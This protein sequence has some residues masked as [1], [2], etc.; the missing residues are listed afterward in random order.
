MYD[1]AEFRH[2]RYLLTI[3]ERRGF[4]AAA[5]ELHTSQPNLSV[6]AKQFQEL[7]SVRLFRKTKSG[8]IRITQTGV[9]FLVL[10]KELLDTRDQIIDAL[11]AIERGNVRSLVFG[12]ASLADPDLFREM[13]ARHKAIVPGCSIRAAYGDSATLIREVVNRAL[14]AAIITGRVADPELNVELVR[15][16]PVVVCLRHDDPRLL[17]A[18]L[19]PVDL[20]GTPAIFYDPE[21]HPEVH[22][23]LLGFLASVGVRVDQYSRASHPS[24]V[25]SLVNDGHG[26]ALIRKGTPLHPDVVAR[27]VAG[28]DWAID[29]QVVYRKSEYPKTLPILIRQLRKQHGKSFVPA[30]E[31]PEPVPVQ[32]GS[33]QPPQAVRHRP[34]Q[35]SL[36]EEV[37]FEQRDRA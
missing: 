4:R 3:L 1:W 27:H 36:P 23:E 34:I 9:A 15:R 2:F 16:D 17:R 10:A 20:Q 12:C 11:V 35:L 7:A 32:V 31:E 33:K 21:R 5:D 14:D 18:A 37:L 30:L 26:Y 19:R 29:T 25:Q 22:Q 13:C 28:V 6:Q 24:E 8:H